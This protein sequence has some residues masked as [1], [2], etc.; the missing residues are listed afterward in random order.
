MGKGAE[1]GRVDAQYFFQ[2]QVIHLPTG[3]Y[4]DACFGKPQT[5]HAGMFAARWIVDAPLGQSLA[6]RRQIDFLAGCVMS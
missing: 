5:H 3:A 4:K 1:V 6:Q 2:S